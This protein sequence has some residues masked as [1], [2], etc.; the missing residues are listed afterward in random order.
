MA[1][2]HETGKNGENIAAGYLK[3]KGYE[4]LATN[5]RFGKMEIDIIARNKDFIVFVEVKTRHSTSYGE[6]EMAV[7][8]D[9]Q[10]FLVRAA[11]AYIQIKKI[12]LEARF[13]I[14]AVVFSSSGTKINHIENA[15]YPTL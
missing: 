6:P 14:V 3:D 11:D 2:I 5:W 9:K 1:E 8:R 10:R 4:I 13:D 7:T 12:Q 15:F